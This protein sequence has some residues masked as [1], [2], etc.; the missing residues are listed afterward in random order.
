MLRNLFLSK[1]EEEKETKA[2]EAKGFTTQEQILNEEKIH[3]QGNPEC[4]EDIQPFCSQLAN[5]YAE[6]ATTGKPDPDT[7]LKTTH[8]EIF[9]A[10]KKER[11]LQLEEQKNHHD[12][13]HPG[14]ATVEYQVNVVPLKELSTEANVKKQ[15]DYNHTLVTIPVDNQKT[16]QMYFGKEKEDKSNCVLIDS[17]ASGAKVT[18]SCDKFFNLFTQKFAELGTNVGSDKRVI[19]AQSNA[20]VL[21]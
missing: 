21:K 15:L 7:Y 2:C 11:E 1:E 19:I 10:M 17:N 4:V 9:A 3:C 8:H 6:S 16:H 13:L 14:F 5:L 18:G 20:P 12:F